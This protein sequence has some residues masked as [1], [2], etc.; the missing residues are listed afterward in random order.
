MP[1]KKEKTRVRMP[2]QMLFADLVESD[3]GDV[4]KSTEFD[5]GFCV[6]L[7]FVVRRL[8]R[9]VYTGTGYPSISIIG[10]Y[11]IYTTAKAQQDAKEVFDCSKSSKAAR[12]PKE[13]DET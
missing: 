11:C 3:F 7:C 4:P 5:F 10:I 6:V 12:I 2:L 9:A 8:A 13:Y 1:V